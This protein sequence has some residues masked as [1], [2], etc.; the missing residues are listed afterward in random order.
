MSDPPAEVRPTVSTDLFDKY[1]LPKIAL[2]VILAGSL[3]GTWVSGRLGGQSAVVTLAKWFYLV[4]LGVLTGGLVWKHCFVRPRDLGTGAGD[5]CVEM[6]ARFDGIATEAVAV[7]AVT[8]PVVLAAYASRLAVGPLVVGLGVLLTTWLGT[9]VA[10]IRG[11]EP[12]DAQFRSPV[13][14][15]GLALA[16][17]VV[18]GTGI[19]E[20]SL[21]GFEPIAA[22]VRTVHLLAFVAWIGG[23]VWNI[24]VA[25]PTGQERPTA[26]VARAAGEQ[27]ERFRWAVR[28]IIPLLFLTGLFQAVTVFGVRFGTYVAAPIGLAVLAKVGIIGLLAVI[29]KLCPM[30]RA[31]SPID[32]VCDL[33]E[34]GAGEPSAG[35]VEGSDDD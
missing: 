26:A 35:P 9:L 6:Y 28:F 21:R 12:V 17:A 3:A 14:L 23:A 32:G 16:L 24:F 8:G 19:A 2:G 10:T 31:C 7:L 34:L 5:Y 11:S 13:G 25:V 30:W 33:E 20:V 4:A 29:F 15:L 22:A 1:V 27:L 18:A